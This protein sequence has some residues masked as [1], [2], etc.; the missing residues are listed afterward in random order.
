MHSP[1]DNHI[2]F[3]SFL[4]IP[5]LTYHTPS[6]PNTVLITYSRREEVWDR[7]G[8]IHSHHCHPERCPASRHHDRVWK[9]SPRRRS[10]TLWNLKPAGTIGRPCWL[11][12]SCLGRRWV[13]LE[14]DLRAA[15][16]MHLWVKCGGLGYEKESHI[17]MEKLVQTCLP[18]P[19][20]FMLLHS[21]TIAR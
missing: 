19:P 9:T 13:W 4:V 8:N 2:S 18:G 15:G 17:Y 6:L 14:G 11:F 10:W 21:G 3:S 5:T 20:C 1:V 16:A 12:V 7:R